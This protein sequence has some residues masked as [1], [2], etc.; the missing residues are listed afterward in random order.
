VFG[1]AE[2]VAALGLTYAQRQQIRAIQT[3]ELG[4]FGPPPGKGGGPKPPA[5][6]PGAK[7]RATDRI[8]EVLTPEQRV[9]WAELVGKPFHTGP[10]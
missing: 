9:R 8:L 3:E 1:D 4:G 7:E 10:R 6:D 2:V 5:A